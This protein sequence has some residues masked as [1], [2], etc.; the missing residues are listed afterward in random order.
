M[1]GAEVMFAV[2]RVSTRFGA[3]GLAW[4]EVAMVRFLGGALVVLVVAKLRGASLR[5]TNQ[6]GAW[7]RSLFGLLSALGVFYAL[8]SERIAVGDVATI[9]ATTPIWVAML[10]GPMLHERVPRSVKYGIALGFAGV[11]VLLQPSFGTGVRVAL[12]ACGGALA[13]AFAIIW[14]RRMSETETSESIAFHMS[15][16][17]GV[18]MLLLSIPSFR[19]PTGPQLLLLML[20]ALSGGLAQVAMTHAYGLADAARMSAVSF[21]GVLFTYGLEAISMQRAPSV[22]Q[23][24]G[25]V[26]VCGAG[27]LVSGVV[28]RGNATT[29]P[30]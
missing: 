21:I 24:S 13:F 14:L 17:V 29:G 7:M 3:R 15:L 2:M 23:I 16:V 4:Q 8:G 27:A 11:L 20:P 10:S 22:V 18:V 9:A 25:A 28:R 1:L 6:K 19:T 12:A 5:V 26:M 30:G